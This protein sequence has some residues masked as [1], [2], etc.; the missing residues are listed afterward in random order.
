M[1]VVVLAEN[2]PKPQHFGLMVFLWE[3]WS[4]FPDQHSNTTS[5]A[6]QKRQ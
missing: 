4:R 3:Q 2:K 1:V 5:P 6:L